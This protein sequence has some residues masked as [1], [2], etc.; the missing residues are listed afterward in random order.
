M[1]SDTHSS[2]S[3]TVPA[4]WAG[5]TPAAVREHALGRELALRRGEHPHAERIIRRGLIVGSAIVVERAIPSG[6]AR[7]RELLA[8]AER[9]GR[10]FPDGLAVVAEELSSGRGRF[11]RAWHAPSGG[12]WLTLALSGSL[13]D[14]SARLLPLAAGVAVCEA[15]R[16][17]AGDAC[18]KW[19]NDVMV[20]GRKC[21]GILI[22]SE[23]RGGEDFFIAGIGV[24]VNNRE[25]P[26]EIED[27]AI[28]LAQACGRDLDLSAF[29]V[30]LMGKLAWNIGLLHDYD[31]VPASMPEGMPPVA[32]RW[33][34]LSDTIGRRVA[35]AHDLDRGVMY[36]AVAE[37]LAPDGS[38]NLRLD[39]GS[40]VNEVSGELRYL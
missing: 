23:R 12:I 3:E 21:A 32:V 33:L 10:S 5:L 30:S 40:L 18:L 19:V 34:A 9:E 14:A 31:E 17:I 13:T 4:A 39:D 38:I 36:E 24:N 26:P 8:A 16:E 1:R 7:V 15:V 11:R 29:A 2:G 28:S 22:E 6:F 37:S 35:F 20:G 25:F 27:T